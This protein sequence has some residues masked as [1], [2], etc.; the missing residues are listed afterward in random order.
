VKDEDGDDRTGIAAAPS[1]GHARRRLAATAGLAVVLVGAYLGWRATT[2]AGL[3]DVPD[4]FDRATSGTIDIP[5]D[6]NAFTFYRLATDAFPGFESDLPAT[7][8]FTEWSEVTP[9]H[10]ATLEAKRRSLELWFEGTRRDRAVHIQP[11]DAMFHLSLPVTQRLLSFAK[12]ANL[13][14]FRRQIEGDLVGAWTW[15]RAN[16]RASRH[17]GTNG[18]FSERCVGVVNF[19][20]ASRQAKVWANDPIVGAGLLRTALDDVLAIDAL[21]PDISE[22]VRHEYFAAM[23][24]LDDPVLRRLW[25]DDG[26]NTTLPTG[27]RARLKHR[28]DDAADFLMHEPER[29]RRLIKWAVVNW[30]SVA[31]LPAPERASRVIKLGKRSAYGT[32]PGA[33]NG[34]SPEILARWV[35]SARYA[36]TYQFIWSN[37]EQT[38][39]RDE[40]NRAG[41]IVHLAEQLHLRDRGAL[42]ATPEA[43]VG[44]YLKAIPAGYDR[45]PARPEAP[46]PPR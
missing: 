7:P 17:S 36:R 26:A 14:A 28:A 3:P 38:F 24:S 39:V 15:I 22:T 16:L 11:R 25:L 30:L 33:P 12:L 6:Q 20:D 44:P 4:P 2:L 41:L 18:F 42:P 13:E 27:L 10:L 8:V 40:R 46:G 21:T 32:A 1:G 9:A 23:N 37:G 35:E 34:V 19:E 45:P 5:D 43:L 29:S 31:K